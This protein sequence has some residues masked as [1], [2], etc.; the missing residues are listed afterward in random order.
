MLNCFLPKPQHFGAHSYIKYFKHTLSHNCIGLH[1][2]VGTQ[3]ALVGMIQ[4]VR[5]F[6]ISEPM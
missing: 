2:W 6:V 3:A 1:R 5:A 4:L